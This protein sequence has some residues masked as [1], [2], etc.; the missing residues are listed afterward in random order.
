M[1]KGGGKSRGKKEDEASTRNKATSIQDASEEG[2]RCP[3]Q[4]TVE[5]FVEQWSICGIPCL[6]QADMSNPHRLL[7]NRR[8]C[9][10]P[11]RSTCGRVRTRCCGGNFI[12]NQALGHSMSTHHWMDVL[13]N[14]PDSVSLDWAVCLRLSSV[15]QTGQCVSDRAL[16]LRLGSVSQ[17]ERCVS[18][19]A[20]FI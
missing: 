10:F 20:L 11:T 1:E 4:E 9:R 7:D 6:S 17:T 15:C 5:L 3:K 18:D 8:T 12:M 2:R 19:R 16:C 13:D 14:K